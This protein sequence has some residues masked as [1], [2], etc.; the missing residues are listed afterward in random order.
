MRVHG[1]MF[2]TGVGLV[3]VMSAS[4]A[5]ASAQPDSPR[6]ADRMNDPVTV[7]TRSARAMR[8]AP[9]VVTVI[10]R[11]D[12]LATGARDLVDVLNLVPGLQFGVDVEGGLGPSVRGLWGTE[13]KVLLLV[14]GLE[15]N[16][17]LYGTNQWGMALPVDLIERIEIIRGPGSVLYGG[18]AEL[19]VIQVTTVRPSTLH[20]LELHGIGGLMGATP[21]RAGLAAAYGQV[22]SET[23]EYSLSAWAGH[24]ITSP[25]DYV[26]PETGRRAA[27]T[28]NTSDPRW[29]NAAVQWHGFQLRL[30][31][32]GYRAA[33]VDGYGEVLSQ[34]AALGFTG[35]FADLRWRGQL[36][37]RLTLVPHLGF[38]RQQPWRATDPGLATFYDKT[39]DTYRGGLLADLV[40]IDDLDLQLAVE[41][42]HDRARL[43][44]ERLL[45]TQRRFDGRTSITV[46]DVAA[47]V[48]GVYAARPFTLV[49]GVRGE[50]SDRF[51]T[52]VVPRVGAIWQGE[53][54]FA[55]A[56]V[57]QAFRTPALENLGLPRARDVQPERT[58]VYE[59]EVGYQVPYRFSFSV[60]A[61]EMTMQ[62]PIVFGYDAA[63]GEELYDNA[64]ETGTQGLEVVQR[65][66]GGWG[67]AEVS[68]SL[69]T[70]HEQNGV[71]AYAVPGRPEALLGAAR[72]KVAL[73]GRFLLPGRVTLGPSAVFL[74]ERWTVVGHDPVPFAGDPEPAGTTPA[75]APIVAL[76]PPT[77]RLNLFVSFTPP[78]VDGL[79]LGAGGYDLTDSGFRYVQPH[80]SGHGPLP[81]AGRE[82]VLKAGYALP[83]EP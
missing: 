47:F 79:Y 73:R 52:S 20:G 66:M 68:Y 43:E 5:P 75:P 14:D 59:A 76:E 16:E 28:G 24:A 34:P 82:F 41:A 78:G 36:G 81:A 44:D 69:Y 64:G 51:E 29:V 42:Y 35:Y 18:F 7:T 39:A 26:E 45:G 21:G 71:P 33:T 10:T 31:Y 17:R 25:R 6:G 11:Q 40:L 3:A 19:A 58:T 74:S 50:W 46:S 48:Q 67:H 57:T 12:I 80:D 30:L 23:L 32:D 15:M 4:A 70:A 62:S 22:R 27:L 38:K 77:L 65:A 54:V 49:A 9:G 55:K 1:R 83:I 60:N 63:E 8:D 61:F 13:G 56:L 72:H 2:R 53:R 37:D